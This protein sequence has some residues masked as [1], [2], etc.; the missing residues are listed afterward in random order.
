MQPNQYNPQLSHHISL[1]GQGMRNN[2]KA[3]LRIMIVLG[4][5]MLCYT[6]LALRLLDVTAGEKT[7]AQMWE[8]ATSKIE[9]VSDDT[10]Q[11]VKVI[12]GKASWDDP[13]FQPDIPPTVLPRQSIS[14]RNGVLLAASVPTRSLYVRPR[15]VQNPET[16]AAKIMEVLP[17][18]DYATLMRRLTSPAKFVWLKRHLTPEEQEK[19]LWAGI[20]G[21]YLH[22]DYNRIYPHGRLLSHVVGYTDVDGVGLAG[23]EKYFNNELGRTDRLKPLELSI[24]VRLQNVLL[25]AVEAG[26][27]KHSAIAAAGAIFHIPSGEARAMVSLPDFDPN[28]HQEFTSQSK[29]NQLSVGKYELG[30]IFKTIS[31]ALALES[32]A[33]KM[34]DS[35]DATLPARYQGG[36]IHDFHAKKRWLNVPEILVY[37]SNIGTAKMV[38]RVGA[39]A[40]REFLQKI[41]MFESVGIELTEQAIP[42]TRATWKPI[43]SATISF[44]HGLSVTP[45]HL[46][47]AL[48]TINGGGVHRE[49][50]LIKGANKQAVRLLSAETSQQVNRLM[51]AVVQHG[52]ASKADVAGYAVGAKTGTA[53]KVINGAYHHEKKLSS[54]VAAFPM[55]NPEYFVFVMFDEPKP[56][57]DTYGYATAGWVAAPVANKVIGEIAA[58]TG[59]TPQ[60]ET[61]PDIIDAM[62]LQASGKP[63]PQLPAPQLPSQ[64]VK[65]SY[66]QQTS[67]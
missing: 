46:I 1:Q 14:D 41:G 15:E 20:A 31:L 25:Q 44:G 5:F 32:G 29:F 59:V 24:D 38:D 30:S 26:M 66:V 23:V 4:C 7:F 28:R 3:K 62:I 49:L 50:T 58:I 13:R 42:T 17:T 45:L 9:N 21:L 52:T 10:M 37:S 55:P 51:R 36:V 61:P 60:Y 63:I 39:T 16:I 19:L 40:Q 67:Y 53:D 27:V 54:M 11:G 8:Q 2:E 33:V 6:A 48:L 18:Q 56:T 22:D 64:V 47:R 65:P 35:F 43:E 12:G 34:E 57:K